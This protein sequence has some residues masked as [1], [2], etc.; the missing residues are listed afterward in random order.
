MSIRKSCLYLNSYAFSMSKKMDTT[1]SL[2]A[3][4]FLTVTS[5]DKRW[6]IVVRLALLHL[7]KQLN[8]NFKGSLE[9]FQVLT[10]VLLWTP[11]IFHGSILAAKFWCTE[12]GESLILLV[13]VFQHFIVDLIRARSRVFGGSDRSGQLLFWEKLII[14]LFVG[15]VHM[16]SFL[17]FLLFQIYKCGIV[18]LWKR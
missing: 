14:D 15:V 18:I 16:Y 13:G 11:T 17:F 7:L 12:Q 1:F 5:T 6:S 10:W 4:A 3:W 2:F 8:D 9:L